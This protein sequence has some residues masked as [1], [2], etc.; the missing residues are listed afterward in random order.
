MSRINSGDAGRLQEAV[1]MTGKTTPPPRPPG[2]M[3]GAPGTAPAP[4]AA[5][6]TAAPLPGASIVTA[7]AALSAACRDLAQN[8]TALME[9]AQAAF[10]DLAKIGDTADALAR[11]GTDLKELAESFQ[12]EQARTAE[13]IK[14]LGDDTLPRTGDK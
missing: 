2:R 14:S 3:P 6:I 13:Q 1:A 7:T 11:T 4:I 8:L 5:Q 9:H 10:T 12:A